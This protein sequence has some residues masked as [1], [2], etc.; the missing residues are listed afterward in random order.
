MSEVEELELLGSG[1]VEGVADDVDEM[2][3]EDPGAR[4]TAIDVECCSGVV[5]GV[6]DDVGE[7]DGEDPGARSTAVDVECFSKSFISCRDWSIG[8]RDSTTLVG[9]GVEHGGGD[10]ASPNGNV[11]SSK[12]ASAAM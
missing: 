9:G 7:M 5:E 12:T 3:G 2:D 10:G 6:V 8:G 11:C 1:V 4:S